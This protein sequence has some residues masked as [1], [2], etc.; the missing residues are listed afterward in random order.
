M[1]VFLSCVSDEF[2]SYRLRLAAQ[3]AALPKRGFEVK[4]QE[5]FQ[6]SGFTLLDQLAACIRDFDLVIHLV[7]DVWA[8]VP[9]PATCSACS[10]PRLPHLSYTQWKYDLFIR[11]E[12]RM[13]CDGR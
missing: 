7:G 1:K 10:R 9:P 12:R 3:L 13:L 8:R 5:D 4:V 2:R 11:F 6:Q